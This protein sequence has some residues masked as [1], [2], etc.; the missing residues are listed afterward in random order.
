M[1][2]FRAAFKFKDSEF[3][4][5]SALDPGSRRLDSVKLMKP[6]LDSYVTIPLKK[7]NHT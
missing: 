7:I 4:H 3:S 2:N 1:I 5:N 6:L